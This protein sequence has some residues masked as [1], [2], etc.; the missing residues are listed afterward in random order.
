MN[1]RK[2]VSL[3]DQQRMDGIGLGDPILQVTY[4]DRFA[5]IADG[6]ELIRTRT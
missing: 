1:E 2:G 4:A 3:S 6:S 5:G